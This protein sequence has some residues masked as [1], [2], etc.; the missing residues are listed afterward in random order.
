MS[1]QFLNFW[2]QTS[3]EIKRAKQISFSLR[4]VFPWTTLF[5]NNMYVPVASC[6]SLFKSLFFPF[7]ESAA[8]FDFFTLQNVHWM[9]LLPPRSPAP[10]ESV[11]KMMQFSAIVVHRMW[12]SF[13]YNKTRERDD[14]AGFFFLQRMQQ[15]Q[16]DWW[17]GLACIS[18]I[19]CMIHNG[20]VT[21][22]RTCNKKRRSISFL[23]VFQDKKMSI[24]TF[25]L[26]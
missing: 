18:C 24:I 23:K 19:I 3:Q 6:G 20:C 12:Y 1:W 4:L 9:L 2:L 17:F 14:Q 25:L 5:W 7:A 15:Q 21:F 8:T 22:S 16:H 13:T 10:F 26:S 11:Y